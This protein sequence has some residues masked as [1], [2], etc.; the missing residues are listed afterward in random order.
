M[1][2]SAY[3]SGVFKKSAFG[4]K[5]TI[6]VQV[7]DNGM[8]TLHGIYSDKNGSL[9]DLEADYDGSAEKII[10]VERTTLSGRVPGMIVR[11]KTE[12]IVAD[13][14][15]MD[16]AFPNASDEVYE[17][18]K[19]NKEKFENL[20]RIR[21]QRMVSER[22]KQAARE[23]QL[24]EEG[25]AYLTASYNKY[26][27]PQETPVYPLVSE[28]YRKAVIFIGKDRSLNF[29][30][31]DGVEKTE[32]VG[33]IPYEKIHYYDTAGNIHYT[34]DISGEMN[35]FGGSFKGASF[36]KTGVILGALFGGFAGGAVAMAASYR[37]GEVTAPNTT[38]NIKSDVHKIDDRSVM[39][40][41]YSDL[42]GQYMDLEL[43]ND[44]YNFL[45]T[46]L[47][48]KRYGIVTEIEK[49]EAVRAHESDAVLLETA[50]A[51]QPMIAEKK[52]DMDDFKR[53]VEK[54]KTLKEAGLLTDE[55]F[56]EE[57]NKLL[58]MI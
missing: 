51:P 19:A 29:L 37:P 17:A 46:H 47:P 5:I 41:Y 1:A 40:N 27:V 9:F 30:S 16:I 2:T 7:F 3:Y 10:S 15:T 28:D 8:V 4:K 13:A 56:I 24:R 20:A 18:L 44:I 50:K 26:I 45:Q 53:K 21:K 31:I 36:S 23:K 14:G 57:R 22:E 35:T 58:A 32:S 55:E 39:L 38:V 11:I 34:T 25:G 42:R 52:D 54:L 43:P 12:S 6:S 33:T 49:R 48:D